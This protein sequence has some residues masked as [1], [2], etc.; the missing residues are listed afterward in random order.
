M[1]VSCNLPFSMGWCVH[2][3]AADPLNLNS[4][5]SNRIHTRRLLAALLLR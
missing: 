1:G 5:K 3:I 2:E 4:S